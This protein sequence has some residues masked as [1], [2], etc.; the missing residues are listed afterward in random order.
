MKKPHNRI[1][2]HAF[3]LTQ[4]A[5]TLRRVTL[6]A[7]T[8]APDTVKNVPKPSILCHGKHKRTNTEAQERK[9]FNVYI[10]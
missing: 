7:L 3:L 1:L 6:L 8:L 2:P 5:S 9:N 4:L 10:G